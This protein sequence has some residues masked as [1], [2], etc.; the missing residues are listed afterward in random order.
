MYR[1]SSSLLHIISL[2]VVVSNAK[3]Q[4]SGRLFSSKADAYLALSIDGQPPRKTET[5]R[6]S[7]TP[8]WN[9]HFTV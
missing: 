2:C 9:E 1:P 3:L 7:S 6:K 8:T 5:V 4:N